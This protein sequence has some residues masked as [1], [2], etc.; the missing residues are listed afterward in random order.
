MRTEPDTLT[1]PLELSMIKILSR[2]IDDFTSIR[3]RQDDS[4]DLALELSQPIYSGGTISNRIKIARIEYNLSETSRD[5]AFSNLILDANRIYL[6]A[7]RS[8]FLFKL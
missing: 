5:D 4:F 6:Q 7:V 2:D 3:K 8:N 1:Y